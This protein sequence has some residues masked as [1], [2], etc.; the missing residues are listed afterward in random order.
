MLDLNIF[1]QLDFFLCEV[2]SFVALT[3]IVFMGTC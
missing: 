3:N 1:G 2:L